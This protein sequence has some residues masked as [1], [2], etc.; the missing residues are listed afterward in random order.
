MQVFL[1]VSAKLLSSNES[2]FTILH[3]TPFIRAVE[4]GLKTED[5]EAIEE[6]A[7]EAGLSANETTMIQVKLKMFSG[8]LQL[9]VY[10]S[11][12]SYTVRYIA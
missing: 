12:V 4:L 1:Q 10:P 11:V 9:F 2:I 6:A 7:A 3:E 8:L 5:L